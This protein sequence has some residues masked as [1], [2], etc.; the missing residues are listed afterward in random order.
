MI[1]VVQNDPLVPAG[2]AGERFEY[3]KVPY[4]TVRAYESPD[5]GN[6]EEISGVVMLGGTMC[7]HDTDR[8]P[9]LRD[10]KRFIAELLRRGTPYFGICLGGQLLA[11]VLGAPVHRN[12]FGE[13]GPRAVSLTEGSLDDPL[14]GALPKEFITFEWHD[15]SFDL[16]A[17]S[18]RLASSE[19]CPNQAFRWGGVFYGLQFHPEVCETIVRGWS[20]ND[21][22]CVSEFKRVEEAYRNASSAVLD[23]FIETV[24]VCSSGVD[25]GGSRAGSGSARRP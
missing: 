1:I 3:E 7:V 14:W 8:F 11:E 23:T 12:R 4:R 9:F 24:R 5:F 25:A 17:G 20:G 18:I 15:D 21:E 16:P 2:L 6:R 13:K 22:Q 19:S 10:V